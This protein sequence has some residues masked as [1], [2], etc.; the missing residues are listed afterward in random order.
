MQAQ[1]LC[2]FQ[3]LL[4]LLF[5]LFLFVFTFA[6]EHQHHLLRP[7]RT[8]R[9]TAAAA[10]ALGDRRGRA[11]SSPLH[12]R[13]SQTQADFSAGA[14]CVRTEGQGPKRV[15]LNQNLP[16]RPHDGG[17]DGGL[18]RRMARVPIVAPHCL[19][20]GTPDS[21]AV[22]T[23]GMAR[24]VSLIANKIVGLSSPLC[25]ISHLPCLALPCLVQFST[26]IFPCRQC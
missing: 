9:H 10:A 24:S 14:A 20:H 22:V 18:P 15:V 5:Y 19:Y 21:P 13:Q 17:P 4:A 11:Y 12:R 2:L 26:N 1:H 25:R 16:R 6:C 3:V 7:R 8:P 23:F